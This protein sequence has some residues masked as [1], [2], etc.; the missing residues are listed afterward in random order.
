M[1]D[2]ASVIPFSVLLDLPRKS[3]LLVCYKLNILRP[4]QGNKFDI[5][6]LLFGGYDRFI[7]LDKMVLYD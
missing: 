5:C 3:T 4:P 2:V 1:F 7:P 6:A